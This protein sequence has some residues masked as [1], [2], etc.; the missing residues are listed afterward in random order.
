M[1]APMMGLSM[2]GVTFVFGISNARKLGTPRYQQW[3]STPTKQHLKLV[4]WYLLSSGIKNRE[5]NYINYLGL[6]TVL[7]F[8]FISNCINKY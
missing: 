6:N 7:K 5:N 8:S 4:R 1:V 2:S 3:R